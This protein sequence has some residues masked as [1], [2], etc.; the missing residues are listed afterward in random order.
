MEVAMDG[1][2]D[3]PGISLRDVVARLNPD[4]NTRE[5]SKLLGLLK[6]GRSRQAFGFQ[7]LARYGSRSRRHFG[8]ASTVPNLGHCA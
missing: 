3:K 7:H 4:S 2:T 6:V 5:Y 8:R 1:A